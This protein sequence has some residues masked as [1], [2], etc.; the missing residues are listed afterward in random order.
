MIG[1]GMAQRR[2][3]LVRTEWA[4]QR[5][6]LIAADLLEHGTLAGARSALPPMPERRFPPQSPKRRF[7]ENG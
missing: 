6:R 3:A 7:R 1:A 2:P 5:I 4:Q